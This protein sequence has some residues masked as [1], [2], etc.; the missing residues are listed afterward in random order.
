MSDFGTISDWEIAFSQI[1]QEAEPDS[2]FFSSKELANHFKLS[3]HRVR[4]LIRKLTESG[5]MTI[6]YRLEIDVIGRNQRIPVYRIE[7]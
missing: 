4:E 1:K 2:G 6:K 7:N 3:R 5:K